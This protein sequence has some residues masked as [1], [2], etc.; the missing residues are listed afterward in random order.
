MGNGRTAPVR[1]GDNY[2]DAGWIACHPFEWGGGSRKANRC[3][4]DA[5][6]RRSVIEVIDLGAVAS[7]SW[8]AMQEAELSIE[9]ARVLYPSRSR[10]R[11][12]LEGLAKPS[13]KCLGSTDSVVLPQGRLLAFGGSRG[14]SS[15]GKCCFRF[16][17]IGQCSFSVTLEEIRPFC[18]KLQDPWDVP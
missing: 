7:P 12:G 14:V 9:F 13:D 17:M 15:G 11:C 1:A 2:L 18:V 3:Y 4:L 16:G 10:R 5:S 6:A 8:R